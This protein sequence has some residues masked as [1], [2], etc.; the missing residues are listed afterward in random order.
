MRYLLCLALLCACSSTPKRHV[1]YCDGLEVSCPPEAFA[2]PGYTPAGAGLPE[3]RPT[4]EEPEVPRSPHKRVLP[5]TP[6]SRR[7]PG[8]W[9]GDGPYEL[10]MERPKLLGIEL[11]MPEPEP[12][13]TLNPEI[14]WFCANTMNRALAK[15]ARIHAKLPQMAKE[16]LSAK[17][18]LWCADDVKDTG[19]YEKYH[20]IECDSEREKKERE[21]AHRAE[22]FRS[23]KCAGVDES[24]I[25]QAKRIAV[26]QWLLIVKGRQQ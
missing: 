8:I 5:Q 9:A 19:F 10:T 3:Y 12:D 15:M 20:G 21:T 16:C 18:F 1:Y 23:E 7:Q 11:P 2:H 22:K 6:A 24:D 26:Q 17:L 14:E 4:E 13:G 25:D